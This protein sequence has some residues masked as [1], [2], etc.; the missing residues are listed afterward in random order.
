[1]SDLQYKKRKD[2]EYVL[3][4]IDRELWMGENLL[5]TKSAGYLNVPHASEDKLSVKHNKLLAIL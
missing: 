3:N 4:K 1:M 2:R 5:K